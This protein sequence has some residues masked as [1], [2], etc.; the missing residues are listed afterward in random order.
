[1]TL[2]TLKETSQA[3]RW[4]GGRETGDQVAFRSVEP[5]TA[6]TPLHSRTHGF[7]LPAIL[8]DKHSLSKPAL[9]AVM[10]LNRRRPLRF[11]FEAAL[12]WAV[13]LGTVAW[14]H[15][16]GQVWVSIIVMIIVATRQKVIASD[17]SEENGESEQDGP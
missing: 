17:G 14:A 16:A 5:P 2:K 11:M 4:P 1:M 6:P 3:G 8:G 7:L 15:W 10:K 9:D 12:A 13:I